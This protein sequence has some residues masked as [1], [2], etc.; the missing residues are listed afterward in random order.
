ML[1]GQS[2]GSILTHDFGHNSATALYYRHYT[3]VASKYT[4]QQFGSSNNWWAGIVFTRLR[5]NEPYRKIS[6][7]LE[8][9]KKIKL[10]TSLRN[11]RMMSLEDW[12]GRPTRHL[13]PLWRSSRLQW[14]RWDSLCMQHWCFLSYLTS[15]SCLEGRQ[16]EGIHPK[17]WGSP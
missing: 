6:N 2:N 7:S 17:A 15:R 13:Q 12:W 14:L 5:W 10:N 4:S 9:P 16:I 11:G 3:D 1:D 8:I